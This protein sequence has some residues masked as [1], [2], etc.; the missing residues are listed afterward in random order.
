[1]HRRRPALAL[2]LALPL[3]LAAAPDHDRAIEA[4]ASESYN[5]RVVLAGR[6]GVRL[7][8]GVATLSG[9]VPYAADKALA[10]DTVGYY[11]GVTAVRNEIVLAPEHPA[12]S[13]AGRLVQLRAFLLTRAGI[14]AATAT[15]AVEHGLVT[16]GG[17]ADSAGQKELIQ[18]YVAE[19]P[20]VKAVKNR[21]VV[22]YEPATRS[23]PAVIVDDA[24]LC[25]QIVTALADH[26]GTRAFK[27]S[28]SSRDGEVFLRGLVNSAS[29]RS[30]AT[31]V[32]ND[33][34]GVRRVT[35]MM[36]ILD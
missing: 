27:P 26:P 1:M 15:V 31:K 6:V 20:W 25:A 22:R 28:V 11:P 8:A 35:N 21:I 9:T 34:L 2:L 30:M 17:T 7:D 29:D 32:A 4:L 14:S 19:L 3:G 10:A 18:L 24:S 16:L 12:Q 23:T 33:I 36:T 13:D 5:L